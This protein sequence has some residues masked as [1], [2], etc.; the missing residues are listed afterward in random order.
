M[1]TRKERVR[2]VSQKLFLPVL[3]AKVYGFHIF[4]L[5]TIQKSLKIFCDNQRFGY[6]LAIILHLQNKQFSCPKQ[7]NDSKFLLRTF[8]RFFFG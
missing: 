3:G 2:N 1:V 8:Q 4:I 6:I 5:C 7:T